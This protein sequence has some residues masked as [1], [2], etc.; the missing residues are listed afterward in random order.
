MPNDPSSATRRTGRNDR[1]RDAPAGFGASACYPFL[2]QQSRS[3]TLQGIHQSFGIGLHFAGVARV[4]GSRPRGARERR[5]KFEEPDRPR[6]SSFGPASGSARESFRKQGDRELA[7]A[8]YGPQR[9]NPKLL[10]VGH[11][12]GDRRVFS[13]PLHNDVAAS[14]PHFRKAVLLQ[15]AT[16]FLTGK[17]RQFSQRSPPEKTRKIPRRAAP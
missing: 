2:I 6:S 4:C 17:P 16:D 3:L 14:L 5:R 12:N 13:P 8:D 15:D 9:T 1:N 10:V 7:L 11:R